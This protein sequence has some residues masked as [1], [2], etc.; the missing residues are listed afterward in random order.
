M[1]SLPINGVEAGQKIAEDKIVQ[2]DLSKAVDLGTPANLS[3][4]LGDFAGRIQQTCNGQLVNVSY[5]LHITA[6]VDG[7]TCCDAPPS[8]YAP[9]EI[10]APHRV[11][12]FFM[13]M[14]GLPAEGSIAQGMP[15][16]YD[17]NAP[18]QYGTAPPPAPYPSTT[19]A[20]YA[21]STAMVNKMDGDQGPVKSATKTKQKV[22]EDDSVPHDDEEDV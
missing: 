17:P 8:A 9:I 12:A 11:I 18:S 21:S 2:F 5:E 16:A 6:D 20:P 7:C 22:V 19:G 1:I 4:A 10:L 15:I 3:G 13:E 14:P